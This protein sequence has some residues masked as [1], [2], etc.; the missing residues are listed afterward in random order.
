[1]NAI[2]GLQLRFQQAV[3][4]G[5]APPGLVRG[6]FNIYAEAYRGRLTEALRE[7]YPV[8]RKAMGD[9]MFDALALAYIEARPSHFRSIRWFG[10]ALA[11]FID[12]HPDLTPHPALGDLARMDWAV[13][14]AFDAAAAPAFDP[15]QIAS[16]PAQDWPEQCFRLQSAARL[17]EL[18]WN[19]EPAWQALSLDEN[20]ST[21]PPQPLRHT[22][23]VW[24][25]ELECQWRSLD[26]HE[27]AALHA[28]A[29]GM[30]FA[31]VC[32]RIAGT[33][34]DDPAQNAA[35]YLR[36]WVEDGL[37]KKT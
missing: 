27:A 33:G 28:L 4:D 2:S 31:D 37:L 9:E 19:V 25:R 32:E 17:I 30:S 36:R 24:R 13:R 34:A 26:A 10:D 6:H 3:L 7:N 8:L 23:L 16:I 21:E 22:L 15:E 35:M 1:M 11:E 14:G 5:Q 29:D 18:Q 20:A 12:A